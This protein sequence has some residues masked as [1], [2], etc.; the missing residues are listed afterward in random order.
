MGDARG[1]LHGEISIESDFNLFEISVF[2]EH[3]S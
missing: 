1:E 2:S 3:E